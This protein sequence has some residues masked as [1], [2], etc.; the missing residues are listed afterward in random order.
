MPR[1]A[2]GLTARQVETIREPGYYADGGGLYLQVAR[3]GAKTW[4]YRFQMAGRRR[5]MGLGSLTTT[6]L[7]E[8]RDKALD[9]RKQVV[10]GTDPIEA[11]K[12]SPTNDAPPVPT[13]ADA[14]RQFIEAKRAGWKNEKHVT[15]WTNTL[16]DYAEPVMGGL[17]IN[18]VTTEHVLAVL[19]P[20]WVEKPETAGRVRGRI[21]AVLDYGKT[22]GWRTGEN[23][24]RW[25]GHLA[26]TLPAKGKVHRV[27]GHMALP[28][29]E[30]PAFWTRLQ[31][32]N[33]MAA[34]ALEFTI[35]T[36]ARTGETVGATW[37]E[38]DLETATWTVPA[39]R[40]KAGQEHRV[41][42]S[43]SALALL[44]E[45][46]GGLPTAFVFPGQK[47]GQPMSNMAMLQ[48]TR[49]LKVEATPHGMRSTFRTW[50]AEQTS[51][52]HEVCEA[53]LAHTQGDRVVAAYQRGDFFEK[54]RRLMDA[55]ASYVTSADQGAAV[56]PGG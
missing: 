24:A 13:F 32:V 51:A 22:R 8:A 1:Q 39:E 33:G 45:L 11:R 34:R 55:W 29:R 46:G 40:M 53:A 31:G 38:I 23:P 17:P 14:T 37:G 44:R 20:I 25:K 4:I 56:R 9:A 49:R 54:R 50:A 27:Q 36:A 18:E 19:T 7:A 48:V 12:A 35:L 52:P 15:Q 43:E 6:S 5:E 28:Y 10:G 16:R 30:M 47:R 2:K 3:T 26:L 41:P 21:E 42:L